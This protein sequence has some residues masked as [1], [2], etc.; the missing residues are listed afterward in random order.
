MIKHRKPKSLGQLSDIDFRLL[1]VFKGVVEHGGYSKAEIALNI[2]RSTI[3]IHMSD[4]ETRLGMT[5]CN[6]GRG[7][8]SFTLTDQGRA[9]YD[10]IINLFGHLNQFRDRVNAIQS[11]LSGEL[12]VAIPDDILEISQIDLVSA[13]R[14][15]HDKAPNVR[16][17]MIAHSPNE[18]D[19][20]ILNDHADCGIN[21]AQTRH[22]ALE[23]LPLFRHS[24]GLYCGER[25]PLFESPP[26]HLSLEQVV[27]Y[28]L[29]G[30]ANRYDS[31]TLQRYA[32]FNIQARANHMS[33]KCLLILSGAYLGFL[34]DYFAE[35][36]VNNRQ[37]K[38]IDLAALNYNIDNAVIYKRQA[39]KKVL[40]E[41]FI[42]EL[43][44]H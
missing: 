34:P 17:E 40:I 41:H 25:H 9:V 8:S 30:S 23:Y 29:V 24:S 36:W 31:D 33:A 44:Q 27:E 22:P 12:R 5:L 38:K 1:R 21:V 13:I 42:A 3:S 26:E 14:H 7:R 19:L 28:A 20:D 32:M 2:S 35:R 15:F 18:V 39:E 11:Q 43:K 10:A 6:R 37:L 4:L 16:I